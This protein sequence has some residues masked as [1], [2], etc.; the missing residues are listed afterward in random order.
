[1]RKNF[2]VQK[3]VRTNLD[4]YT[5]Y[6]FI[7]NFFYTYS[8]VNICK[9]H[10]DHD[11][12]LCHHQLFVTSAWLCVLGLTFYVYIHNWNSIWIWFCLCCDVKL[13]HF[14][15]LSHILQFDVH[16][17]V[18]ILSLFFLEEEQFI[19]SKHWLFWCTVILIT[20]PSASFC[21]NFLL[22][23][24]MCTVI[25]YAIAFLFVILLTDPFPHIKL[26]YLFHF[27]QFVQVIL[28]CIKSLILDVFM[29]P[30][31]L[32]SPLPTVLNKLS[33]IDL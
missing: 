27:I 9:Y 2:Y 17:V 33:S 28:F 21:C 24:Y 31:P 16:Q 15:V 3:L 10:F 13:L 26:L 20:C 18:G 1:M 22:T 4:R 12:K 23:L 5:M 6:V 14:S 11:Q 32:D 30:R 7:H 19:C 8:E 29:F 25:V